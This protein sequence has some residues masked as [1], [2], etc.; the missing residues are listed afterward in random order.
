MPR[1]ATNTV[2]FV[3]QRRCASVSRL[4]KRAHDVFRGRGAG[5]EA[6]CRKRAFRQAWRPCRQRIP[7]A[8][9]GQG[10]LALECHAETCVSVDAAH[11]EGRRRP[12]SERIKL[13][14]RV[15][16]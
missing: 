6:A 8:G 7:P 11:A 10:A 4:E 1:V 14:V 5:L 2:P 9:R 12:G 13:T 3:V 15:P 16:R